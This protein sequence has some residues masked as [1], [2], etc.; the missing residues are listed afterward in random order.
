MKDPERT[1]L[2]D[3]VVEAG[4]V[5][6]EPTKKHPADADRDSGAAPTAAP[7]LSVVLPAA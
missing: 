1:Q 6:L 7:L 2:L 3:D 4:H 5:G